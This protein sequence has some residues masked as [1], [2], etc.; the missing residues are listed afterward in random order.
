[1]IYRN[2]SSNKAND[3]NPFEE[4]DWEENDALVDTGE[5]GVP[6][7]AL[8]DYEGAENDELSFK[9]G[10]FFL[11]FHSI[12]VKPVNLTRKLDSIAFF[13]FSQIRNHIWRV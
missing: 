6:V 7:K 1:M 12:L 13:A 3:S 11:T 10:M 5:P 8:Y 9:T 4:E 2:G